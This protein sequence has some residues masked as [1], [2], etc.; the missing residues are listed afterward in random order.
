M[1]LEDH[2]LTESRTALESIDTL[3]PLEIVRLINSE[4]AK[5]VEAVGAETPS[6]AQAMT[7]PP[8]G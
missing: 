5:V 8:T 2:L 7:G 4:D 3:S 6:I 1:T